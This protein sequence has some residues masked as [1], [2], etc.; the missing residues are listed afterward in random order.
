VSALAS[1]RVG[2]CDGAPAL[3]VAVHDRCVRPSYPRRTAGL[4]RVARTNDATNAATNAATDG[5]AD[6]LPGSHAAFATART[7][8]VRRR[9]IDR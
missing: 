3:G 8:V 1:D 5:G 4:P 6:E 9:A 2:L 7:A